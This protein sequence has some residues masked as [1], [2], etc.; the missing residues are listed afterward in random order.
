MKVILREDVEALG[1]MGDIV[2]VK[3]GYARN[4]LLPRKLAV[5]ANPRN[6]KEFEHYRR[7]I[8][9]R[10]NKVKNAAQALADRI[11]SNPIEIRARAGE[12]EKLF[13]SVTNID[14]EKALKE[15]GFE[16]ERRR[17]V[18]DEP[19]KRLGEYTVKV[20]LHPEVTADLTVKV[21]SEEAAQA[22]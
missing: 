18:L 5:E 15:S 6:V 2:T 3:N 4:Y 13:G 16:I 11:A 9:E 22:D 7:T 20:R 14:I 17:I 8:Q 10:A 19:I 21:I 12:E 1:N